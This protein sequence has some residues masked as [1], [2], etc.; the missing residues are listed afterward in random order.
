MARSRAKDYGEKRAAML[1]RAAIA[2]SRDGYDRASMAGLAAEC[3]VSKALLYHYYAAKEALLSDVIRNHLERLIEAV[4]AAD[5]PGFPPEAKL[6]AL[7]GALLDAYKDADAEHRVQI[8]AMRLLAPEVQHELK[9]LERR[10]VKLFADAIRDLNPGAFEGRPLLKPV[11]MALFGM[12]NWFYMWFREG[13]G[14]TR[15]D[16]AD[17][18]TGML[19]AGVRELKRA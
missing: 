9:E 6:R 15:E 3:G 16:Y 8:E 18:A 2:F 4:E 5:T 11:T 19:V 14:I 10:L 12:L 13:G 17:L 1:H 7:V